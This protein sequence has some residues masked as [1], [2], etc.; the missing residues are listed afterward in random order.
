[1]TQEQ[2]PDRSGAGGR[3]GKCCD[4]L[5]EALEGEDFEPLISVGPEDILYMAVGLIELEDEEPGMID[6]PIYYCPFC[7][8]KLQDPE[9]VK[10]QLESV[11]EVQQ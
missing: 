7:G 8:T 6:H 2:V 11:G 4:E 9:T 10:A 5:K 1:M 3:F